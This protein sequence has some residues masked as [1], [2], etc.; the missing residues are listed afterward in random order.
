MVTP[1]LNIIILNDS[2][3]TEI[4]RSQEIY[5]RPK[6]TLADAALTF[7]FQRRPCLTGTQVMPTE[8]SFRDVT[9]A[10]VYFRADTSSDGS[11]LSASA[12][13]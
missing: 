13:P 1:D 11:L 6:F 2:L 7:S 3:F 9:P 12:H 5:M 8:R 4:R 10:V